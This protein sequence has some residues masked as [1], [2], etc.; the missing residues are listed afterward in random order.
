MFQ[1]LYSAAEACQCEVMGSQYIRAK[2]YSVPEVQEITSEMNVRIYDLSEKE[3]RK[4][5]LVNHEG[6]GYWT[7]FYLKSFLMDYTIYFPS[8]IT[9]DDN[10]FGRLVLFHVQRYAEVQWN[11][12]Y[13]YIN[14]ESISMKQNGKYLLDRLQVEIMFFDE[15]KSRGFY[16]EYKTEM[17]IHFLITYFVNTLHIIFTRMDEIPYEVYRKMCK[18][19]ESYVPDYYRNPYLSI[20]KYAWL[21]DKHYF[22]NLYT[23]YDKIEHN[24]NVLNVLDAIPERLRSYCW[25]DLIKKPLTDG[26]LEAWKKI[27][28]FDAQ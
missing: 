9:W 25:L 18:A 17:E 24:D 27:Y 28:L 16:G 26:E 3:N 11:S 20:E 7:C 1:I 2:T 19:V 21:K 10:F 5:F 14:E 12:Y 22:L 23:Y 8:E 13:W 6:N 15:L 4:S